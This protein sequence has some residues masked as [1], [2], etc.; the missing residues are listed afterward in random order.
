VLKQALTQAVRWQ[1]LARSP[2]DAVDPPKVERTAMTTYD[3]KQTGQLIEALRAPS[4]FIPT[5]LAV[6]LGMRQ[7]EIAA[8]RWRSVSLE[9]GQLAVVESVEQMNTAI[10]LKPQERPGEDRGAG[11]DDLGSSPHLKPMGF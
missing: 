4:L 1:L 3:L 10:G 11:P 5:L 6:L 2:A 9:T 8:L 7:G